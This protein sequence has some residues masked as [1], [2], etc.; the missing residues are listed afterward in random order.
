V[1]MVF[2]FCCCC[3]V[4]F[5]GADNDDEY[6]YDDDDTGVKSSLVRVLELYRNNGFFIMFGTS[7]FSSV[8]V[9]AAAAAKRVGIVVLCRSSQPRQPGTGDCCCSIQAAA[10][11]DVDRQQKRNT[12]RIIE[13]GFHS[14]ELLAVASTRNMMI[15]IYIDMIYVDMN[16]GGGKINTNTQSRGNNWDKDDTDHHLPKGRFSLCVCVGILLT[17]FPKG[18]LGRSRHG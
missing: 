15:S 2:C 12:S 3:V 6:E 7:S 16:S 13:A 1:T 14:T 10:C 4:S 18:R 17:R 9:G 5:V 8:L 11:V